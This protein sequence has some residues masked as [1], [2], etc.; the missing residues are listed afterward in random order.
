MVY[1][2][3]GEYQKARVTLTRAASLLKQ[4]PPADNRLFLAMTHH[5]LGETANAGNL[6]EEGLAWLKARPGLA[7]HP[8]EQLD[9]LRAEA[10]ALLHSR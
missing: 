8:R 9:A 10:D 4:P 7:G 1:Y 6:Y 2:R 3:L 5:R